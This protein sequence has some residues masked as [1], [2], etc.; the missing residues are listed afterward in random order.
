AIAARREDRL[1]GDLH[2]RLVLRVSVGTVFEEHRDVRT[3]RVGEC[4]ETVMKTRRGGDKETRR[5][6]NNDR[7]C[8][9]LSPCLPIS[10]SPCLRA[11][12]L[13]QPPASRRRAPHGNRIDPAAFLLEGALNEPLERFDLR[14]E[15]SRQRDFEIADRPHHPLTALI[16]VADG[17]AQRMIAE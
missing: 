8:R 15:E 13:N 12:V 6:A 16:N 4:R 11:Y 2:R 9:Y 10:L 5:R 3:Q 17:I 14:L 7:Q 1:L